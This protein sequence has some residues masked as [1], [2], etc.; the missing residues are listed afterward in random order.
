MLIWPFFQRGGAH[1]GSILITGAQIGRQQQRT[2]DGDDDK[3]YRHAFLIIEAK[4]GPGG[5]NSRHVLCA[6]SDTE[7][8][9]WVD[10]LVR[11]ISGIFNED[12]SSIISTDPSSGTGV[13]QPRSSISSHQDVT[14]TP[15]SR[16]TRVMPKDD[17]G[18]LMP[19]SQVAADANHAK[20]S[21]ACVSESTMS[22]CSRE[23]TSSPTKFPPQYSDRDIE[24]HSKRILELGGGL[25]EPPLSTS[26]PTSSPLDCAGQGL[27]AFR[28]NSEIGH[29]AEKDRS[30]APHN[31]APIDQG[32]R[33]EER[34]DRKSFIP[35][36]S[37]LSHSPLVIAFPERPSSPDVSST[38]QRSGEL[39]GK[40]KISGPI[41]GAP[42][43]HGFKFGGKDAPA[44]AAGDKR[45]KARLK[46]WGF[47]KEKPTTVPRAVFGIPLEE[48]LEIAE[49]A[50]LPA[51][52]FRC[53]QYLENKKAEEEEGIYRLSGSS[54]VIKGLRD[55]FNMGKDCV[56]PLSICNR[57]PTVFQRVMLTSFHRMKSGTPTPL[58]GY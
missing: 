40:I 46:I 47:G 53:I 8:D 41:N 29:Y 43:P 56:C 19:T 39:N 35:G 12:S 44:D 52:V 25:T 30:V 49:L 26:L 13:S 32:Q 15:N 10:I 36:L 3:N 27:V 55:R 42:I 18:P 6:E 9:G 57:C 33:R 23:C 48:S 31:Q 28:P 51:V 4:K 54:A 20:I 14:A 45:E 37:S 1:L 34:R 38:P 24:D 2:I 16:R 21:Q 50:R 17:K 7:R 58:L 22:D 11:Y 5:T